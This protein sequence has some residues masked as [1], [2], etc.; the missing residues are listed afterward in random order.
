[1]GGHF[2]WS[3]MWIREI[4]RVLPGVSA[5][6]ESSAVD[7]G[8]TT[9]SDSNQTSGKEKNGNVPVVFCKVKFL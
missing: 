2:V 4:G 7:S 3:T 6:A 1:M 5:V 9:P 8:A